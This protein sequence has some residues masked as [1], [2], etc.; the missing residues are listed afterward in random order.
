MSPTG[1][2]EACH[3]YEDAKV[4]CIYALVFIELKLEGWS[5][6]NRI[7]VSLDRTLVGALGTGLAGNAH[8]YMP[9]LALCIVDIVFRLL[10]EIKIKMKLRI[11]F[12]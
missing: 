11:E 2:T 5:K 4:K 7:K 6:S 1:T 3:G 9:G 12:L 8:G 10:E